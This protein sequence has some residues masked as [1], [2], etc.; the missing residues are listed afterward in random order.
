MIEQNILNIAF[1]ICLKYADRDLAHDGYGIWQLAGDCLKQLIV[2]FNSHP[3]A[4]RAMQCIVNH[5]CDA[6]KAA[7]KLPEAV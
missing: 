2:P 5:Y 3:L 1:Q 7:H 6:W 4:A